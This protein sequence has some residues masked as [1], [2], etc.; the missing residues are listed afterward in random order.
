MFM[1][2]EVTESLRKHLGNLLSMQG[3]HLTFD[4]AVENFPA[5]ARGVKPA[6]AP[7]SAWELLEHLRLAQADILGKGRGRDDHR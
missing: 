3:A 1:A 6:G 2:K 4:E 7:H 5:A